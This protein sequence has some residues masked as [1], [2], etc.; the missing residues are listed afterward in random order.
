[1]TLPH[2][3]SEPAPITS[4]FYF[5]LSYIILLLNFNSLNMVDRPCRGRLDLF[6]ST[7]VKDIFEK[8][9]NKDIVL[10]LHIS[11]GSQLNNK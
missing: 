7:K 5:K 8:K 2:T 3:I 1:M 4:W 11:T 9:N 6:P 10:F